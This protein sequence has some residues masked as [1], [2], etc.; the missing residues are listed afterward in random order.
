[1]TFTAF[2]RRGSAV[3]AVAALAACGGS[4]AT[5]PHTPAQL[6]AVSARSKVLELNAQETIVV[7]VVDGNGRAVSGAAVTFAADNEGVLSVSSATTGGDGTAT[8]MLTIK[9]VDD[10]TVVTATVNGVTQALTY[11]FTGK[12]NTPPAGTIDDF[13]GQTALQNWTSFGPT[14]SLTRGTLRANGTVGGSGQFQG[15]FK[16]I[17]SVDFSST[18]KVTVRLRNATESNG[19]AWVQL[20]LNDINGV[21]A[22]KFGNVAGGLVVGVPNDGQWHTY[23]FDFTGKWVQYDDRPV[24]KTKI[25][26]VV[27]LINP[28]I[29]PAFNGTVDFDEIQRI[30]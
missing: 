30:P 16:G 21:G 7:R 25:K 24:D 3:L 9:N 26:E 28:N 27:F 15:F 2:C 20:A 1:M 22:N 11:K 14:I 23:T 5:G 10:P 17:G 4:D 12:C 6:R 29:A 8:T 18:Q 13:C 19:T